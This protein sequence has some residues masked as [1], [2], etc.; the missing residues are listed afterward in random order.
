MVFRLW[1]VAR[2]WKGKFDDGLIHDKYTSVREKKYH[3]HCHNTIPK[4]RR[5]NNLKLVIIH[6]QY[7]VC[8]SG[9]ESRQK[10]TNELTVKIADTI[11]FVLPMKAHELD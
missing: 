11:I 7:V 6:G 1:S 5:D 4:P 2:L 9:R 3:N 8:S 10:N